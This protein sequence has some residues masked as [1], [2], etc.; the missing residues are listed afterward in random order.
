MASSST[1]TRS[2]AEHPLDR[3]ARVISHPEKGRVEVIEDSWESKEIRILQ[4]PML[5]RENVGN[6]LDIITQGVVD[7][8]F[9]VF[10]IVTLICW[11]LKNVYG[12]LAALI[13]NSRNVE[14][15]LAEVDAAIVR[16]EA[17]ANAKPATAAHAT[18]ATDSVPPPAAPAAPRARVRC[19]TCTAK[20][21]T[22]SECKTKDIQAVKKRVK[23]NKRHV[24]NTPA[25]I[26]TTY[27]PAP[28]QPASAPPSLDVIADALEYRR[29]Q[30]QSR[31]DK[32]RAARQKQ[33]KQAK[34]GKE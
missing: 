16:M 32:A 29:R 4:D 14:R 2:P 23:I 34:K 11:H 28:G 7:N 9:K 3:A 22:A 30:Q 1:T 18:V 13:T 21:H 17:I 15:K 12:V 5:R 6:R 20:G 33:E 27:T 25:K 26:T 19:T 31:R 8:F 24:N 10:N